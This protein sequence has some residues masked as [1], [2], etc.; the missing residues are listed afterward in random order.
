MRSL[1]PQY[2]Y[3]RSAKNRKCLTAHAL[4]VEHIRG[5][6]LSLLRRYPDTNE[7]CKGRMKKFYLIKTGELSQL[8]R[9]YNQQKAEKR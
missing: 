5:R 4:I 7:C 9:L 1:L 2:P 6:K 3:A 8:T